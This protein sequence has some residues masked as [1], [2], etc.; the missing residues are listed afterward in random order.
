MAEGEIRLAVSKLDEASVCKSLQKFYLKEAEQRLPERVRFWHRRMYNCELPELKFRAMRSR[1]GSCAAHGGI[2]LNTCLLRASLPVIDY[3]IV[4][5]LA[6]L[7][8]FD[9]SAKFHALVAEV[10]PDWK[11][12][13]KLLTV[14]C[15]F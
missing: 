6:H 5:E 2:T 3:V 15:G 11:A 8:H 4:H 12:R 1:W 10:L 9:H 13:K 14:P 7:T